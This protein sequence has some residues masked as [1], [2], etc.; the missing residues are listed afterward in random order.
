MEEIG[1][2]YFHLEYITDNRYI[3]WPFANSLAMCYIFPVLVHCF[4][5]K[6]GNPAVEHFFL[7]PIDE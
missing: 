3:L 1:L 5:K 2:L 4:K 6:S 7:S